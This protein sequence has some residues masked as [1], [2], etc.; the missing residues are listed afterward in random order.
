MIPVYQTIFGKHGNCFQACVASLLELPLSSVPDFCNYQP[1][2]D[3]WDFLQDWFRERGH[4]ALEIRL[5]PNC[6]V[7]S[8]GCLCVLSGVGASGLIHSVVGRTVRG[9]FEYVFDPYPNGNFVQK[10]THALFF[11]PLNPKL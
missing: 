11:V 7:W 9:G 6:V 1:Q 5:E 10:P 4:C 8:E 3:W 2:C